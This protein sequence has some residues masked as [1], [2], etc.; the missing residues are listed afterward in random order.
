MT[1]HPPRHPP[2]ATTNTYYNTANS[3]VCTLDMRRL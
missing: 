1:T 2:T 3:T